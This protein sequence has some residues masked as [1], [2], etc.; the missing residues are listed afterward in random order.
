MRRKRVHVAR[1][2]N[3]TQTFGAKFLPFARC[4]ECRFPGKRRFPDTT[5]YK[6]TD[7]LSCKVDQSLESLKAGIEGQV[8]FYL[9]FSAEPLLHFGM[10]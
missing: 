6:K 1:K 8:V 7:P 3:S 5:K 10:Y 4:F 9:V 2:I